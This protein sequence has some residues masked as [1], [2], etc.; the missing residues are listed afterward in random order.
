MKRACVI[1]WPIEHSRSPLIHNH[2]LQLYGIDGRYERVAVHPD[3]LERFLR[4]MPQEGLAGCNVTVPHKEAVFTAV[5][6]EDDFTRRLG[7]VNTVYVSNGTLYG[8]N[9]DGIGFLHNLK[10][11][12]P[13]WTAAAGPAV[14]LGAGGAARAVAAMLVDAG[15]PE[16][17]ILNRT[18]ERAV[19]LATM[20]APCAVAH[21][22]EQRAA[23]LADCTLLVNTTSLGM[24]GAPPL[25]IDLAALPASA[26]VN[27]IVYAPLQ[28]GLL[29][30]AAGR[31]NPVVD[32]LGM[33]LHQ[34]APGFALWFGPT[35]Q[36]TDELRAL[37]VSDLETA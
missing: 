8:T 31:G 19:R 18:A 21:P 13:D 17:R 25:E 1:G 22:W 10:A 16:V 26:T 34:A 12:S 23:V 15:A 9:T 32:G 3:E 4:S 28:T 35:P 37:I 29:K 2:W 6:V 14:I 36:V 11:G 27:D 7:A 30:R 24:A 5:Q 33:L 20:F